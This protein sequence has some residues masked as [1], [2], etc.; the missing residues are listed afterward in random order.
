MPASAAPLLQSIFA[1]TQRAS[2]VPL[3]QS[4]PSATQHLSF[5]A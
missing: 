3:L 4:F 5:S 2:A 1:A